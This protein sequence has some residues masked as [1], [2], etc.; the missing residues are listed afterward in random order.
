MLT[1]TTVKKKEEF[2]NIVRKRGNKVSL[3]HNISYPLKEK[4]HYLSHTKNLDFA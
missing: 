4:I 3:S 2:E 1:L